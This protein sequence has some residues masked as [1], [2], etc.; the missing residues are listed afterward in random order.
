MTDKLMYVPNDKTLN[1]PLCYLQLVDT[2]LN[3]P[4]NIYS[5]K[6]PKVVNLTNKKTLL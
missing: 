1:Y 3:E 4:T 2:Q 6:V 5:I